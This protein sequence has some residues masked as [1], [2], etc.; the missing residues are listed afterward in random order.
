MADLYFLSSAATSGERSALAAY[1]NARYG[2]TW[3][4]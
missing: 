1:L 3:S 4:P 2:Q